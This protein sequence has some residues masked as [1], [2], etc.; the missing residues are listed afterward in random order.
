MFPSNS[1]HPHHDIVT[2]VRAFLIMWMICMSVWTL[3]FVGRI[4]VGPVFW[5]R[6][7]W[8]LGLVLAAGLLVGI[9][10]VSLVYGF[11]LVRYRHTVFHSSQITDKKTRPDGHQP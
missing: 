7:L 9:F 5:I 6:T 10:G 8:I 4:W 2:T 3:A 11:R 1:C